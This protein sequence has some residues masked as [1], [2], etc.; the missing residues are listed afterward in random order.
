LTRKIT[1]TVLFLI[2]AIAAWKL[3]AWRNPQQIVKLRKVSTSGNT[4]V[5]ILEL[6]GPSCG[7][8]ACIALEYRRLQHGELLSAHG[9]HGLVC[10]ADAA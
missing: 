10:F 2:A 5:R 3:Y 4:E 9:L 8:D 7:S 6:R 1:A